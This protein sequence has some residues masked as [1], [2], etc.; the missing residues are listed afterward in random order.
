MAGFPE[1]FKIAVQK[2]DCFYRSIGNAVCPPLIAAI[3]GQ[4]ITALEAAAPALEPS[5]VVP[6][7]MA[8]A[9]EMVLESAPNPMQRRSADQGV[10]LAARIAMYLQTT[11]E[12][13]FM[14]PCTDNISLANEAV[15]KDG[16]GDDDEG[17]DDM[18]VKL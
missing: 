18:A 14:L 5:P 10:S 9:L 6:S 3:A 1:S 8:T 4:L 12:G 13:S 2:E 11:I 16:E 17:D 15:I 7:T